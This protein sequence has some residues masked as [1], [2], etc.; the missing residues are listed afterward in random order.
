MRTRGSIIRSVAALGAL[1]A[2]LLI[3]A[4]CGSKDS[5]SSAEKTAADFTR[6]INRIVRPGE[7]SWPNDLPDDVPT[8]TQG[9]IVFAQKG[10]T[11][12]GTQWTVRV[13]GVE[14]GGFG[15][16]IDSLRSAGW[17]ASTTET[18]AGGECTA[19]KESLS[20]SL[21]YRGGEG[22]LTIVLKSF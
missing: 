19:A 9:R 21:S 6:R 11:A 14:E 8:F 3:C 1:A 17:D 5:A 7:T 15:E 12:D 22:T 2:V 4:A 20:L 16:Y 13:A 18:D 10:L